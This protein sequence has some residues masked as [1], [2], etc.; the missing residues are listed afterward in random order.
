MDYL[1]TSK[2]VLAAYPLAAVGDPTMRAME[3]DDAVTP[4]GEYDVSGDAGGLTA[5]YQSS[6]TYAATLACCQL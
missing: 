6:I 4:W 3:I 1:Y 2:T 5:A